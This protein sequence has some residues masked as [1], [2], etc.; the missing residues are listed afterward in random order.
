MMESTSKLISRE[1]L[2]R[3]DH[4]SRLLAALLAESGNYAYIDRLGYS[5]SRDLAIF[6]LREALR[7]FSSINNRG[8]SNEEAE[9]EASRIVMDLVNKGIEDIGK[10]SGMKELRER[11]SLITAKALAI[12]APLIKREKEEK[13]EKGEEKGNLKTSDSNVGGG[14]K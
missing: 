6:Y 11:V 3:I 5:Q 1:Q 9:K 8:W 12:A 13:I 4:I 7:D 14:A 2:L 10:V